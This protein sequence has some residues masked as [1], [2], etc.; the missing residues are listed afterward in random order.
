MSGSGLVDWEGTGDGSLHDAFGPGEI[1]N[2]VKAL[3][4]GADINNPGAAP[5]QGFPLRVESLDSTLH[6]LTH[7]EADIV[8]WRDCPKKPAYNT[9]EEHN[10][11]TSVGSEE[12]MFVGEGD[13]PEEDDTEYERAYNVMKFLG[14]V[15]RVSHPLMILKN[16]FLP[17]S[18]LAAETKNATL[19]ILRQQEVALWDADSTNSSVQYDGFV[20]KTLDGVCRIGPGTGTSSNASGT[21]AYF[22]NVDTVV[23]TNLWQDMRYGFLSQDNATDLVTHIADEPNYGRVTDVYLPY[24]VHRDFSK[25]FYPAERMQGLVHEGKAGVVVNSWMSPFGTVDLKP[26]VFLRMSRPFAQVGSTASKRPLTPVIS[27]VSSPAMVGG[28]PGPGF[29]GSVQGRTCPLT[30]DGPGTY[31]YQVVACNRYG[32]SA[33]ASFS[34]AVAAADKVQFS[35]TDNSTGF[36]AEWYEIA[37]SLRGGAATTAAFIFRSKKTAAT[38]VVVDYNHYIPYTGRAFFV[39]RNLQAM[40]WQQLLP[41]LKINLAQVD[42]TVRFALVLYG[43]LEIFAP[44]KHGIAF[45]IGPLVNIP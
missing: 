35:V 4:A 6:V 1:R 10:R 3:R 45:N 9:I 2:L 44:R 43:A 15:R 29:G 23:G 30:V 32:R 21:A 22:A 28:D 38:Q 14:T 24:N 26:A 41:L 11:L 17:D 31:A 33:P 42:L 16:N 19:K 36:V 18:V 12:G 37:R 13:L 27:A 7:S 34:I 20:R 25:Q 5:G 40:A 8:F 39:Q